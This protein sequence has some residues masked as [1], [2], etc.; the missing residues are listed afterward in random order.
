MSNSN[1]ADSVLEIIEKKLS[2]KV[3]FSVFRHK[4][5]YNKMSNPLNFWQN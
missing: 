2:S 5:Q 1:L 4:S 3:K